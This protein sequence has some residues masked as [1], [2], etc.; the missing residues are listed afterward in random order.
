MDSWSHTQSGEFTVE[1]F[2]QTRTLK[3]EMKRNKDEA[4]MKRSQTGQEQP[5][6]DAK[7]E[8]HSYCKPDVFP[9]IGWK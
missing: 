4:D 8:V 3:M 1:D 5:G 9:L 2:A 6:E 7:I